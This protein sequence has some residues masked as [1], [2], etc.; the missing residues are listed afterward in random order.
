MLNSVQLHGRVTAEPQYKEG[1][2]P[3]VRFSLAVQ[4]NF[5]NQEGNYDA[6]FI[7]CM[8]FGKRANMIA[9]YFHKGSEMIATGEWR[10]GSYTNQQGQ[11]IYTNELNVNTVDFAG[12]K[13]P[14]DENNNN[15]DSGQQNNY[16]G[17]QEVDITDDELPF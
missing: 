17:N 12:S 3:M 9:Q 8:A 16:G 5:K 2:T 11:K 7:N 13:K 4:R 6:D 10:T 14:N 15:Q 1:N